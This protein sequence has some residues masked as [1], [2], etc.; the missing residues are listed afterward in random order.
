M[1]SNKKSP[2]FVQLLS[3]LTAFF[4][5]TGCANIQK[6]MGGPRDRTPPKLLKAAPL[7][8]TRNFSAKQIQLDFDEYFKLNNQYTEITVTPN[9][10]KPPE[11]DIKSKSLVIKLKD[12]LS[13]NTTYVINFGKAIA[14]VNEGNVLKNFTYVFSTGPNIDSLSISGTVTNTLTQVKEKD[15]TVLL[16]PLRLDTLFGK[17]K[18]AI[19]TT[20]DSSGNFRLGN[21]HSGDYKIYALKET[22]VNKIY[23]NDEELIAFQKNTIHLN[24][25]TAGIRLNLFKQ[26]PQKLK[27][28]EK[29]IDQDGKLLFT[30]NKGI[31][32]I[33]LKIHDPDLNAQKFTDFSRNGDT[34]QV[35]LP[36]MAFDSVK[37]SFLSAGKPLDTIILHK[38]KNE[39]YKRTIQLKYNLTDDHLKPGNDLTVTANYPIQ[40]IDQ[41]RIILIE[42]TV[43]AGEIRL[44]RDEKN[45]KL[46]T[47]KYPWKVGKH[48]SLSFNIGTFTDIYGDRNGLAKKSFLLDKPENYGVLTIKVV[49]PDTGKHYLV[50]LMNPDDGTVIHSDPISKSGV[51]RYKDY[52]TGKYSMRVVYDTNNNGKWDTGDLKA[53]IYPENIWYLKKTLTL[54]TN[55]DLDDELIVPKEPTP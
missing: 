10:E 48:Y 21:L 11:F 22:T 13:K 14:D 49:L 16:F 54:R 6:P 3:V 5:L 40:S 23:D 2:F 43:D 24:K 39:V 45:P 31:P 42:D 20:T 36:N 17:K 26:I 34:T 37:V 15:V 28:L 1:S 30:F 46:F 32:D 50:Q 47:V 29:R 19:Y 52:P 4:I 33:G 9:M 25:D 18:P 7:N 38:R 41:S 12:T 35:Y 44:I 51:V 8:Q 55:F 27:I 53:K